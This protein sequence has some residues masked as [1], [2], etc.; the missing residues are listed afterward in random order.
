[1][2][3]QSY[4]LL[5]RGEVPV[6]SSLRR[7]LIIRVTLHRWQHRGGGVKLTNQHGAFMLVEIINVYL[8]MNMADSMDVTF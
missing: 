2:H 8:A 6:Y 1:M 4:S 5:Q 7:V 3:K